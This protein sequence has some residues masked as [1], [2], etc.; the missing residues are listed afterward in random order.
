MILLLKTNEWPSKSPN[1]DVMDYSMW[2]IL[3]GELGKIRSE[4]TSLERLKVGLILEE[5]GYEN[6]QSDISGWLRFSR[7]VNGGNFKHLFCKC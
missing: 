3:Q 7:K 4:L 6:C 5:D 1:W 2:G